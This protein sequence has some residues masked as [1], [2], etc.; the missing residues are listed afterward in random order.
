MHARNHAVV[1][2][3]LLRRNACHCAGC[4]GDCRVCAACAYSAA[5]ATVVAAIV[6]VHAFLKQVI[7]DLVFL[8]CSHLY[9]RRKQ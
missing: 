6:G 8:L 1:S 7:A 4:G 9:L 5:T 3:T 2:D